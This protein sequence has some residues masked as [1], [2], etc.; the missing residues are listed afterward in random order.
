VRALGALR[1]RSVDIL[2]LQEIHAGAR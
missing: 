2:S 1:A